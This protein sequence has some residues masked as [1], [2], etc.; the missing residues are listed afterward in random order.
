MTPDSL[1]DKF[2]LTLPDGTIT[3]LVRRSL[4]AQRLQMR[5][6]ATSRSFELVLPPRCSWATAKRFAEKNAEWAAVNLW[7][8]SSK[9]RAKTYPFVDGAVIP[10]LG[11]KLLLKADSTARVTHLQPAR[12]EEIQQLHIAGR[13]DYFAR[14]VTDFLQQQARIELTRRSHAYAKILG[15]EVKSLRLGDAGTRW[16]SCSSRGN[17]NYSWRLIFA[18]P[19]VVDYVAAHEVA[20]LVELNHSPRFWALVERLIPDY[21]THRKWL[22][23]NGHRLML[24]GLPAPAES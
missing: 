4:K 12:G 8:L 5:L 17:L 9:P 10:L 20:H 21:E 2:D 13:S 14:R 24:I 1:P 6:N 23:V 22:K 7:K 16:G 11:K 18:P 3:V 15:V 19:E